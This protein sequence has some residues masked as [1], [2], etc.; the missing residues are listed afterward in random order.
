MPANFPLHD[1]YYLLIIY[2]SII[3][4]IDQLD[5]NVLDNLLEQ[6]VNNSGKF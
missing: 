3:L 4:S 1:E 2:L 6:M 5:N